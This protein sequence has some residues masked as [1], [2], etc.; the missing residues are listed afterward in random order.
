MVRL[1]YGHGAVEVRSTVAVRSWY[2]HGV[3]DVCT[4]PVRCGSLTF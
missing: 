1:R 4:L 3:V 2:A